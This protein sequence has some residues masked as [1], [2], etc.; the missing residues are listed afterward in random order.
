[1]SS[2]GLKRAFSTFSVVAAQIVQPDEKNITIKLVLLTQNLDI[3]A[4]IQY[5]IF[6]L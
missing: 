6:F 4:F 5:N 3:K 1:M 2:A